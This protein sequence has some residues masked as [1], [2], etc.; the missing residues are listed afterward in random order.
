M[1]PDD[2]QSWPWA[3]FGGCAAAH[4]DVYIALTV[5]V[6]QRV[7]RIQNFADQFFWEVGMANHATDGASGVLKSNQILLLTRQSSAD[8]ID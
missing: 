7:I 4:G 3:D 5:L 8:L 1:S 2:R 6:A